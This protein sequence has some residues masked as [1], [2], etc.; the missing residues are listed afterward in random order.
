MKE[1]RER[2]SQFRRARG[3]IA[4]R[5]ADGDGIQF[6]GG[7]RKQPGMGR[8]PLN[9]DAFVRREP[10]GLF[11]I[12]GMPAIGGVLLAESEEAEAV[13]HGASSASTARETCSQVQAAE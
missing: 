10:E 3:L 8:D 13:A 12:A 7:A 4:R 5:R 11:V 1:M 9:V 2:Q 6:P